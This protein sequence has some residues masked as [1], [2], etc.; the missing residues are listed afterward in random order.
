LLVESQENKTDNARIFNALKNLI[1]K[2]IACIEELSKEAETKKQT[3]RDILV[4]KLQLISDN[5]NL[6]E[7]KAL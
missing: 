1:P 7:N 2:D 5:T 3:C 4:S 6:D